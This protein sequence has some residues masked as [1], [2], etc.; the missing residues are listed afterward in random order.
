MHR[1]IHVNLYYNAPIYNLGGPTTWV[2]PRTDPTGFARSVAQKI[3]NSLAGT[4]GEAPTQAD[5]LAILIQ[6]F[7]EDESDL[8]SS[9]GSPEPAYATRFFQPTDRLVPAL[10][11][12]ADFP[13]QD[14]SARWYRHPFLVNAGDNGPL[15]LWFQAFVDEYKRIQRDKDVP[16]FIGVELPD[17]KRLLMDTE[18]TICHTPNKNVVTM[19]RT[20]AS[21]PYKA[22]YWQTRLVPTYDKTLEELYNAERV[23]NGWPL[24]PTDNVDG[25]TDA[26]DCFHSRN[27][28]IC[29]WYKQI[30]DRVE[31]EVMYKCMF[32]IAETAWPRVLTYGN[33]DE[34]EV[35]GV[36]DKTGWMYDRPNTPAANGDTIPLRY[37]GGS[38]AFRTNQFPRGFI[39]PFMG[40]F[41]YHAPNGRYL[42]SKRSTGGNINMPTLYGIPTVNNF[43]AGYW[44][45]AQ[46]NQYLPGWAAG[47]CDFVL[48]N[49][50]PNG[51]PVNGLP[52]PCESSWETAIRLNRHTAESIINSGAGQRNE[53]LVPW[54]EMVGTDTFGNAFDGYRSEDE[55]RTMLAMLRGKNIK[56]AAFWV[57]YAQFDP[58]QSHRNTAWAQTE[59][60]I[61][62]VYA[63]RVESYARLRGTA[64]LGESYDPKRLEYTLL[65]HVS[66]GTVRRERVATIKSA[67]IITGGSTE[68]SNELRVDFLWPETWGANTRPFST[69][70]YAVQELHIYLECAST[71]QDT[72]GHVLV[73]V[74]MEGGVWDWM[75]AQSLES[76][77][78]NPAYMFYTDAETQ[79]PY[80]VRTRRSFTQFMDNACWFDSV[81]GRWKTTLKLV[82]KNNTG[83]F[84][85]A[86]DLVQIVPGNGA[87][88]GSSSSSLMSGAMTSDLNF[89]GLSDTTDVF[90]YLDDWMEG[91]GNADLNQDGVI[92]E[93]DV[94]SFEE[95]YI[96]GE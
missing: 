76:D 42:V 3:Y 74:P 68:H 23:A 13:V 96:N 57:N 25:L 19:I 60:V 11:D 91:Y 22:D 51:I 79:F 31:A 56:E 92:D 15:A 36:M 95:A 72:I 29:L 20:L 53:N 78:G 62:K 58:T 34:M 27:R 64:S 2:V 70:E 43:A 1:M 9:G 80:W 28:S 84:T 55:V 89:D 73:G 90:Q 65:E 37:I 41:F 45:Q 40:G 93:V 12:Q 38:A 7:G 35:D 88:E 86:Y 87:V 17:P 4:N 5:N 81:A 59:K 26:Q 46:T 18:A 71:R 50:T 8:D 75:Y 16:G 33:Y 52:A 82:H 83:S 66:G 24:D 44:Q 39:E 14:R 30:C 77:G 10:S 6:R 94:L 85:S 47:P 61:D 21:A 63:A 69:P 32:K 67:P 48:E 54:I 49:G